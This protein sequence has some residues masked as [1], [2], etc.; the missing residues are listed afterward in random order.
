MTVRIN[1]PALNVREE[2]SKLNKPS[3]VAGEAMLRAE[4]PQEQFD[5]IGAGRKNLII[6]G[7][8][9]VAQRGTSSTGVT[10][11]GY[12]ACDR[13]R[14]DTGNLGE[15]IRK[16]EQVSD[17]PAGFYSSHKVT[18]TTPEST[19]GS[20]DR[21]YPLLY[22]IEGYDLQQLAYGTP[23]A[24]D[25]TLSFWVKVSE[26]GTYVISLYNKDYN[27]HVARTYTVSSPNTWEYKSFTFS[28]DSV[29]GFNNDSN[30]SLELYFIGGIGGS[31]LSG[32]LPD[33][34]ESY[35]SADFAVGQ[36]VQMHTILNSTFQI[37]GVQLELGS[38]ATPFEHRSYG[39]ELALC[40]RF[41]VKFP[42]QN[43]YAYE[44]TDYYGGRR[45]IREPFPV[46]MRTAP[47][48]T[49]TVGFDG[50]GTFQGI[51]SSNYHFFASSNNDVNSYMV[52]TNIS[53]D[54]EL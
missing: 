48:M 44:Y 26:T 10:G 13:M 53:A 25:V 14:H 35:Y 46:T 38:V 34:W 52:L 41:F 49:Y 40:Q 23:D 20:T 45:V 37:T 4:T 32:S 11:D 30:A 28:G 33:N 47:T 24:K 39:E 19:L 22:R 42:N 1:K 21:F 43:Y 17:A 36:T 7:A 9:Q 5:L 29:N 18:V 16:V 54:A 31:Y 2:L 8:M 3:G 6:N 15:A 50:A 12:F 27:R 51:S